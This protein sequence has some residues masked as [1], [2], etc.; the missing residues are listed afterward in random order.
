MEP[1]LVLFNISSLL[2][3]LLSGQIHS[4]HCGL[5]QR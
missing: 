5:A 2:V 4:T 3:G 1:G